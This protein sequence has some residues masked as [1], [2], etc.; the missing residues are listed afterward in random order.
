[1]TNTIN[2][3]VFRAFYKTLQSEG[4]NDSEA[5]QLAQR[6][7]DLLT[8]SQAPSNRSSEKPAIAAVDG[9]ASDN[10]F[11]DRPWTYFFS[12]LTITRR[13]AFSVLSVLLALFAFSFFNAVLD[14]ARSPRPPRSVGLP[15][16]PR[17]RE[18]IRLLSFISILLL[19]FGLMIFTM[20]V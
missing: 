5:Y 11:S 19:I 16:G 4:F 6:G 7:A 18:V 9:N 14:L 13:L 3:R 2:A 10:T 17:N 15:T 8:A 1:M 12:K 20:P